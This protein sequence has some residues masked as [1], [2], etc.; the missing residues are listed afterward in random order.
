ML[1]A[2]ENTDFLQALTMLTTRKR[3]LADTSDRP[4]AI[5][6]KREDILKL[7][8][9]DYLEWRDPLRE[10]FTWA[11]TFLANR[12]IFAHRDIPYPKQLVPLAAIKVVLGQQADLI[13]VS[14]RLMRWFWCGVLG[15]L[16]GSAIETRFARDIEMVP[17]WAVGDDKPD[18]TH[19]AGRQLHRVTTA[20]PENSQRRRLQG[21]RGPAPRRR[22]PR[23][24]G[25]QSARQD[26]VR[27]PGGRH[28]PHLPSEV[29]QRERD[30]R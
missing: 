29:V 7:T 3:N 18:A 6:A 9:E 25:R 15:E 21:H 17:A 2:V 28:P 27:R 22:R 5:S 30:R 12:H 14:D 24:D 10:A 8:L 20:L 13:A 23:L 4:P 1:A 26:P 19:R 16:Y 11:A